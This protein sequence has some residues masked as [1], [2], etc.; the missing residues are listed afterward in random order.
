MAH[1]RKRWRTEGLQLAQPPNPVRDYDCLPID[2]PPPIPASR[3]TAN[4]S[5][6][7][8]AAPPKL[9]DEEFARESKT[10][11]SDSAV[12]LFPHTSAIEIKTESPGAS[13]TRE[14]KGW[15]GSIAIH[16]I[17]GIIVA[18]LVAPADFGQRPTQVL[19]VRLSDEDVE[20]PTPMMLV[21]EIDTVDSSMR[22][23]LEEEPDIPV[24]IPTDLDRNLIKPAV[25]SKGSQTRP[26]RSTG[27][28]SGG[29]R[30]S[31]FGIQAVGQEFVYIV[32]RSGSMNGRRFRRAVGELKRSI[33]ELRPDQRFL[34]ILFSDSSKMMFDGHTDN[35][36]ELVEAT[37]ENKDRFSDW[38]ARVK[39]GG[40]TNPNSSLRAALKINPSA[41]FMLSD[42]EFSEQKKRNKRVF[43]NGGTAQ[44]IVEASGKNVPVHAIAFE[45]PRS[46]ENMKQL[47]N[48]SGGE[49]RFV[50]GMGQT[51]SQLVDDLKRVTA[52]AMSQWREQ[53]QKELC[54]AIGS[55][56]VSA[57]S[58]REVAKDLISEHEF[59]R[60][61]WDLKRKGVTKPVLNQT[62]VLLESLVAIDPYRSCCAADQD[63]I[64]A[65]LS[66]L[67]DQVK[68]EDAKQETCDRLLNMYTSTAANSILNRL[69][70][71]YQSLPADEKSFGRL[72]LVKQR[73]PDSMVADLFQQRV[74][75]MVKALIGN[76]EALRKQ[77]DFVSAIKSLRQTLSH[78]QDR[79]IHA[80]IY[81]HL[82]ELTM[83]HLVEARDAAAENQRSRKL[84]IDRQLEE[85]FG[86]DP[87]LRQFKSDLA[88]QELAARKMLQTASEVNPY[89]GMR[90]KQAQLKLIVRQF[91]LTLAAKKARGQLDDLSGLQQQLSD[92]EAELTRMMD[93]TRRK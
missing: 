62:V 45:D 4:D 90:M 20:I 5:I 17:I 89:I 60:A 35:V 70:G 42:G 56:Q 22:T 55:H 26:G 3:K 71:H 84:E 85:A 32:D 31:F 78:Q 66:E 61:D 39:V 82:R 67:L 46:C 50:N 86:P 13:D 19:T 38:L 52:R 74:D 54:Q 73:H 16:L 1:L 6:V 81:N 27:S 21:E 12:R 59:L 9:G 43:D 57:K 36:G 91:P 53:E 51:E 10:A 2:F 40:G 69:I 77:G 23:T 72:K 7:Y 8:R 15:I 48:A 49:Y 33:R 14:S 28:T 87:A 34:V 18:L 29:A 83:E 75:V 68:Q 11:S 80:M 41:I 44:S 76:S 79:T 63:Q 64:A 24:D 30:G 88:K 65:E 58:K 93:D 47:A 37:D 92:D 25:M